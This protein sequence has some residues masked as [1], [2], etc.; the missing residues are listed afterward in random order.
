MYQIL[1]DKHGEDF[2][3][4]QHQLC[5]E[6]ISDVEMMLTAVIAKRMNIQ[7]LVLMPIGEHRYMA[8]QVINLNTY[9]TVSE[10]NGV[11]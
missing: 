7:N 6:D 2:D 11:E 8:F 1:I 3:I 4:V 9:V 10:I 5:A